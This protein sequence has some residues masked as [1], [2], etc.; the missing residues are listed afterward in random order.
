M[1]AMMNEDMPPASANVVGLNMARK[2]YEEGY[3]KYS[4]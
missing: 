3:L 2:G 1:V 4:D